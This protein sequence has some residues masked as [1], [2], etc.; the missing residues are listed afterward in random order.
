MNYIEILLKLNKSKKILL[1]IFLMFLSLGYYLQ[2]KNSKYYEFYFNIY[3][4]SGSFLIFDN[5]Q[6]IYDQFKVT[7]LTE[8]AK[9]NYKI[10]K[11]PEIKNA[12]KVSMVIDNNDLKVLTLKKR[13]VIEL[14]ER[15]K[16]NLIK[17]ITKNFSL[18]NITVNKL[19]QLESQTNKISKIKLELKWIESEKEYIN[20]NISE[21]IN[22]KFPK[23]FNKINL[24]NYY[25]IM[26]TLYILLITLFIT[27]LIIAEDLKK[28]L[29]RK[30]IK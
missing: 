3:F 1:V 10:E 22:L 7:T 30:K 28:K 8:L 20:E 12:Y 11:N 19:P 25:A 15:Q 6:S 23:K 26:I 2:E 5:K 4:P 17:W 21:D 29:K 27:Y 16:Q 13:E 24:I 9:K 14:F 18:A